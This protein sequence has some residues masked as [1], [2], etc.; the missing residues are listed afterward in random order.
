MGLRISEQLSV[1]DGG[2]SDCAGHE[3]PSSSM[4]GTGD[5]LY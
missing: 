5:P 2:A 4:A 3:F 1:G